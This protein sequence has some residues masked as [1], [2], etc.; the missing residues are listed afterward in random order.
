M[1]K[2]ILT[3]IE[4]TT[5]SI[6]FVKDTLFPYARRHLP[7][8]VVTHTDD[9]T[10]QHWLHEAAKEAGLVSA[11]QDELIAL[12]QKWIDEDRKS[13][14]LKALQGLIWED[15]Y[16]NGEY[17]AHLYPDV[18]PAL[19]KWKNSGLFIAVYSSG[20]QKAQQL[21]FRHSLE[22]NIADR[23]HHFFD[24][25]FGPKR[26][27]DSYRRIANSMRMPP[28]EFLFLSDVIEELD[29]A[30]TA[31]MKT[32]LLARPPSTCRAN[33]AHPCVTDFTAIAIG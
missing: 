9:L 4:G 21:F 13:T 22:G 6:S 10:V 17:Q 25:E 23:F 5:S 16:K 18:L 8:F 3:D 19:D 32:T 20:S 14:A 15:G 2:A 31:G 1:I 7:A 29:A 11:S 30:R 33:A 24:T 26:E 28:G 27:P 12:L